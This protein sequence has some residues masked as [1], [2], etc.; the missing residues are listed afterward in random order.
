V[1]CQL[2]VIVWRRCGGAAQFEA[3]IGKGARQLPERLAPQPL[4]DAAF[5]QHHAGKAARVELVQALVVGDDDLRLADL[6]RLTH[7]RHVDAKL[8]ALAHRLRGHGQRRQN[9][10]P[11]LRVCDDQARPFKLHEGLAQPAFGEDGG[12]AQLNRP[13]H[14]IALERKQLGVDGLRRDVESLRLYHALL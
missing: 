7:V 2:D 3:R 5:V 11:A 1:V 4:Q 8:L 12:P 14:D 9:Q 13:A 10:H 6:V